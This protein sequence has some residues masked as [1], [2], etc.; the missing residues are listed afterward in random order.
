MHAVIKTP[1]LIVVSL[2][3]LLTA[4]SS[5]THAEYQENTSDS[6]TVFDDHGRKIATFTSQ[7]D[8]DF[9]LR[10]LETALPLMQMNT[11][12]RV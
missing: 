4:C 11:N 10:C 9:S 1:M 7:E 8:L 3:L 2:V 5:A 6:V 12:W